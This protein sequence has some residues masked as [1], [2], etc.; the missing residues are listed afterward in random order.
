LLI[1]GPFFLRKYICLKEN[2]IPFKD[3]FILFNYS[4]SLKRKPEPLK[5]K[6]YPLKLF[7]FPLKEKRIPGRKS[8][9]LQRI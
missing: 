5:E 2:A 4:K 1:C 7:S 3:L 6:R 8:K 9:F